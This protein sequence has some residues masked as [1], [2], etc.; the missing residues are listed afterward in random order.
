[1]SELKRYQS[2]ALASLARFAEAVK[3]APSFDAAYRAVAGPET[4]VDKPEYLPPPS[5]SD[6]PS[7]CLQVPTGGGKTLMAAHAAGILRRALRPDG[8]AVFLWLAPSGAIVD[9]TLDALKRPG[10]PYRAALTAALGAVEVLSVDEALQAGPNALSGG[11]LVIV[12]TIQSFRQDKTEG[13]KVYEDN[14]ALLAHFTGRALPE[15]LER[16][17]ASGEPLRSLANLLRLHR[18]VLIVDE[19]H[20]ACTDLSFK[21]WERLSPCFLLE[22][23]ATPVRTGVF[24]SNILHRVTPGELKADHMIKMPLRVFQREPG[25]QDQLLIDAVAMRRNLE[26]EAKLEESLTGEYIRPVLLIQ[27]GAV[28][29]CEPMREKLAAEFDIPRTHI[30]VHTGEKKTELPDRDTF[31]SREC[32]VRV[33]I[34][35][36]ALREGWDCPF[37]YVLCSYRPNR[38]DTALQQIVGRVLRLPRVT[39]KRHDDLNCGYVFTC[40]ATLGEALKELRGAIQAEGFRKEEAEDL[41]PDAQ[42]RLVFSAPVKVSVDTAR[43]IDP[44]QWRMRAACLDGT[45]KLEPATGEIVIRGNPSAETLGHVRVCIRTPEARERFDAAVAKVKVQNEGELFAHAE[46]GSGASPWALGKPFRVPLLAYSSPDGVFRFDVTALREMPW[47]L[48]GCDA[49]LA[50][51]DPLQR[52]K[53]A[54]GYV[55]VEAGK[56]NPQIGHVSEQ[57]K[58]DFIASFRRQMDFSLPGSGDWTEDRL[59]RWFAERLSGNDCITDHDLKNFLRAALTKLAAAPARPTVNQIALDRLRLLD[60]LRERIDALYAA[61]LEHAHEELSRQPELFVCEDRGDEFVLDFGKLAGA[62]PLT[63]YAGDFRFGKHYDG[64]QPG[65]FANEEEEG[66]A[67]HLDGMDVVEFWMRNPER[68]P[69]FSL[70]KSDGSNFFPDFVAKLTD[71]RFLAVEY[72]GADRATNLDSQRK[73]KAGELWEKR[74]GGRCLFRMITDKRYRELDEAVKSS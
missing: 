65:V 16:N 52:D 4:G 60:R 14:G 67:I 45:V 32:P 56:D 26:D 50:G 6:T 7:V 48:S 61:Q 33:V 2:A 62:Y 43:D 34:T 41:V 42:P 70:L 63:R 51:Y 36:N 71:G 55:D 53:G 15:D 11:A 19:A 22:L 74:S 64:R 57:E 3:T 8:C 20:N 1:M 28:A 47:E 29:D 5:L 27:L 13:R 73:A 58:R 54:L 35:V 40:A 49:T 69:A 68:H 18:P 9:Q 39:P 25:R 30:V 17:K 46:A 38:S 66:C 59:V 21:V 12:G 23:T 31:L 10:H 72:K 37:V 44:D 24:R